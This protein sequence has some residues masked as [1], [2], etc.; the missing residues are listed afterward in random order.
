MNKNIYVFALTAFI[1][2]AVFTSCQ[3]NAEKT[4][5]A[6]AKVKA[7]KQELI[8]ARKD[9]HAEELKNASAEEW[10]E[11]HNEEQERIWA[12]E[13]YIAELKVKM[14]RPGKLLDATYAKKIT[15]LEEKN[16]DMKRRMDAYENNQSNWENFKRE[17]NHDMDE[18]GKALTDLTIDNTK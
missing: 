8:E 5:S 1:G 16:K 11:F 3:S 18:L 4:E 15:S 6:E 17:Y 13:R 10:K 2:G 7:A 14:N 12:N 9:E